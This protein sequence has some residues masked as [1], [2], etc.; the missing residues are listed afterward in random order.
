MYNT[1]NRPDGL[2][3]IMEENHAKNEGENR[4][5]QYD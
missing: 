4:D 5:I 2:E 1:R 3:N